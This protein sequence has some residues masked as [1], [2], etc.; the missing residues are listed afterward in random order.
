M[1]DQGLQEQGNHDPVQNVPHEVGADMQGLAGMKVNGS[2]PKGHDEDSGGGDEPISQ[3]V[4]A[5]K[6][7][8]RQHQERNDRGQVLLRAIAPRGLCRLCG[9]G[10]VE[11]Q[12]ANNNGRGDPERNDSDPSWW[13]PRPDVDAGHYIDRNEGPN[14]KRVR[15][16]GPCV[17]I[18]VKQKRPNPDTKGKRCQRDKNGALRAGV[19][20]GS[21]R[22]KGRNDEGGV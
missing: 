5:L 4:V 10:G 8:D 18:G 7:E 15:K 12:S 13:N 17:R 20:H 2:K 6:G 3:R 16:F 1:P 11:G 19:S 22:P 21:P 14:G 9:V